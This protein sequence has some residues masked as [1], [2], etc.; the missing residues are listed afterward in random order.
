MPRD[1]GGGTSCPGGSL[2][3]QLNGSV[4]DESGT[5]IGG[6][7]VQLCLRVA[8]SMEERALCLSPADSNA[9]GAFQ[10]MT[11]AD[12]QCVRAAAL[13]VLQ[14]LTVTATTYCPVPLASMNGVAR[15]TEPMRVY[16][17]TPA[18]SLPP[19]GDRAMSR[20]VVLADGLELDV[21][22][23]R[24]GIG[25]DYTK[26]GARR[27]DTSRG[28]PCFASSAGQLRALYA[29]Q[30]ETTITGAGFPIRIPNTGGLAAGARVDLL[31][32]GGLDTRLVSGQRIEE[33]HFEKFGTG[34][35]SADGRMIV[36]DP[37]SELPY[38]SWLGVR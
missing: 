3:T 2:I 33:S 35:V 8:G 19:E 1:G 37:G 20:T 12:S 13:R 23:D 22:P 7:K 27:I 14:P 36:A 4:A 5:P 34:T 38:L 6:A 31:V 10:I 28:V 21:T 16:G 9:Q 18:A 32:L 25:G 26:F 17:I 29:F 30:P 24:L 11:P 15:L